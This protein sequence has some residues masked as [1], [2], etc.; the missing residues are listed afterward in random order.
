MAQFEE[1]MQKLET[2]LHKLEQGDLALEESVNLFE[3]GMQLAHTCRKELD[4]AEGRIQKLVAR[5]DGELAVE[6]FEGGGE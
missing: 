2:I 4:A 3:Q 1:A 5:R 6:P